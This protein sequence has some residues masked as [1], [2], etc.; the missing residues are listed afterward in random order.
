MVPRFHV[1][2]VAQHMA[3]AQVVNVPKAWHFVFIDTP[4]MPL[5][6][7]DGDLGADPAGFDRAAFL[8]QLGQALP[9]FFDQAW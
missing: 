7:P 6:S 5:P 4:G 3:K 2:W 9:L 1:G 8:E